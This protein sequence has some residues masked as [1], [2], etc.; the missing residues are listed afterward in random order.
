MTGTPQV[1]TMATTV[2]S[3]QRFRTMKHQVRME[4]VAKTGKKSINAGSLLADLMAR[5][6]EKENVDFLDIHGVPFDISHFPD[7]DE[8]AEKLAAETVVTG[9]TTKV[10]IGFFMLSSAN[11]QRIKLSIGYSWLGQKNIYLRIQRMD[12][13]HGTD[14]FFMGYKTMDNPMVA[15]PKEVEKSIRDK[16]YSVVDRMA[17]EHDTNEHDAAF[18]ANLAKLEDAKLV[19]NDVLQLPISVERNIVKVVCPG[20]KPFEVPVFQVYVPRCYRDAAT[21]LNDRAILETNALKTLIPFSVA[22]NDPLAFYPQ[23]VNHAKFLHDHRSLTIKGVTSSEFETVQSV[24]PIPTLQRTATLKEALN[25]NKMIDAIHANF[26]N[27]SIT[28]STTYSQFQELMEWVKLV[29]PVFPYNPVLADGVN[30]D[31]N[32]KS[33]NTRGTGKYSKV[34]AP[35]TDTDSTT[36]T[37][38]DP[39]TIA[40]S[41]TARTNAWTQGP[42]INVTFDRRPSTRSVSVNPNPS[43]PRTYAASQGNHD[44]GRTT[45]RDDNSADNSSDESSDAT[46][47]TRPSAAPSDI[48]DLVEKALASEREE[49]NKRFDALEKQQQAFNEATQQWEQKLVDMRKQIVD[50]TVSGTISILTGTTSPFAT[51]SDAHQQRMENA[52][53][54]QNLKESMANNQTALDV[55]QQHMTIMLRRTEQIFAERYDPS[56]ESPP[57][58]AR[59]K[60]RSTADSPMT[61]VTGASAN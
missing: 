29:T 20:K 2:P 49:L 50:A 5:A 34:F 47:L 7:P 17:A 52:T 21:Y 26:D 16:W 54:F 39:S 37:T 42:P 25:S 36:D 10:T 23:M 12:F 4:I 14:L 55:L 61:D 31:A 32:S 40:S 60:D 41:R 15:N 13:K 33:E 59:A 27:K 28:I 22:K 24:Q 51:K 45:L 56:L 19:V 3:A 35:A 30:R 8:F 43:Q 38:F 44:Y 58:K 53:E 6:N 57:R 11:M 46:P 1:F 9:S 48:A 18:L